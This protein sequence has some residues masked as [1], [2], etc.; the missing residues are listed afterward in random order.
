MWRGIITKLVKSAFHWSSLQLFLNDLS[1]GKEA[2]IS[3][4]K[5]FQQVKKSSISF[6]KRNDDNNLYVIIE[7]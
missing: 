2:N 1:H 5:D 6:F 4:K 3:I 7:S